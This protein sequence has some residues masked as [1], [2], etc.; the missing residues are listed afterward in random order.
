MNNCYK[1]FKRLKINSLRLF[2]LI[3]PSPVVNN[4]LCDFT[5]TIDDLKSS[6]VL[7]KSS[8]QILKFS[9]K[10]SIL[11]LREDSILLFT[12]RIEK[13]MAQKDLSI[14]VSLSVIRF[15]F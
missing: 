13:G 3:I 6:L 15:D 9:L 4:K 7:T 1:A 10:I 11:R 8:L 14:E 5:T 12:D 2:F